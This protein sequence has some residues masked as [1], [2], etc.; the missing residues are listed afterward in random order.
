MQTWAVPKVYSQGNRR[1]D[2]ITQV[3]FMF[4]EKNVSH[5]ANNYW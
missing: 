4:E 2:C 1:I 5:S 3:A